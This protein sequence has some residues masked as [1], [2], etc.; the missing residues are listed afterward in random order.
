MPRPAG[1]RCCLY[2]TDALARVIDTMSDHAAALLGRCERLVIVGVLRRGAPLADRLRDALVARHGLEAP[3]RLDLSVKRYADD[4]TLLFPE[5]RLDTSHTDID[6]QGASVLV[7]DDVLYSGHSTL[8]VVEHLRAQHAAQIR[9]AVLVDRGAT[10]LP[11]RAD[12]VGV[13]LEVAPTDIIECNVPPYEPDFRIE[14]LK[15]QRGA[16]GPPPAPV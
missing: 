13:R 5:V 4:L 6:L 12:I 14:V 8:R 7:V 9:L 3:Q 10:V 16:D 11:V 15:P 1:K 2:D